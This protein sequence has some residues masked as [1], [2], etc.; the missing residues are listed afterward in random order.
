MRKKLNIVT[1]IGRV[2]DLNTPENYILEVPG[3]LLEVS[4]PNGAGNP[5]PTTIQLPHRRAHGSLPPCLPLEGKV[6]PKV[7]DEVLHN[8][9]DQTDTSSTASGP[10]CALR[11]TRSAA[12]ICYKHIIHYRRLRFAYLKEKAFGAGN[13]P[14]TII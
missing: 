3:L 1:Q 5:P 11:S 9:Y 2:Q 10:P 12:L 14:P 6:S 8:L 4:E 7:T 13:P